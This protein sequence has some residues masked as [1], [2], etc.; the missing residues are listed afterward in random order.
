ML[1]LIL[2]YYLLHFPNDCHIIIGE[3]ELIEVFL[4]LACQLVWILTNLGYHDLWMMGRN[5]GFLVVQD[6]LV[7]FLAISESNVLDV[8][9]IYSRKGYHTLCQIG[10]ADRLAHIEDE[11]LASL[12]HG[13]CLQ[14]QLAGFWN[15]HEETDDVGMG[16]GDRTAHRNLLLED[17]DNGAVAAQDI[18]ESCSDKLGDALYLAIHN[19]LVQCLTINLADSLAAAHHVGWIHSLIGRNHHKLLCTCLLYTSPSPRDRTSSRKPS[20]A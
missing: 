18:A 13:S 9:A 20:S 15:E 2:R 10:D 4:V 16:N 6:F 17:W 7:K 14:Y 5:G 8:D 12:T 3:G 1:R 11:D 19:R